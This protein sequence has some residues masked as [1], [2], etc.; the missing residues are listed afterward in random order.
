VKR[1]ATGYLLIDVLASVAII[2]ILAAILFPVFARAREKARAASCLSNLTQ[3]GLACHLYAQD[4]DGWFPPTTDDLTPLNGYYL[5]AGQVFICP[6]N[7]SGYS[8]AQPPGIGPGLGYQY[9]GGLRATAGG[10]APVAT[11]Q[12]LLHNDMA[13]MLF[14]D[15]H[16]RIV[17]AGEWQGYGFS[18]KGPP[19][20]PGAA[21]MGA[22]PGMP[23]GGP[24]APG[25]M[26]GMGGPPGAGP[27]GGA[28]GGPPG[29]PPGRKAPSGGAGPGGALPWPHP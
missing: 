4:H 17:S 9:R 2:A 8:Q 7:S 16:A 6:S 26:P 25:G 28:P 29:Y 10:H 19:G 12:W 23:G 21:G 27:P 13:N 14:A 1:G 15:G 5:K 20:S 11:D 18:P 22:P 24:G 3:I